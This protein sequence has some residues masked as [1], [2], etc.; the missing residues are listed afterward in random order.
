MKLQNPFSKKIY[1]KILLQN[2]KDYKY[3]KFPLKK[4][5][6]QVKIEDSAY[7]LDEKAIIWLKK[8]PFI[9]FHKGNLIPEYLHDIL[10]LDGGKYEVLT[11][12]RT[13]K[14]VFGGSG[15]DWIAFIVGIAVSS[16]G[17]MVLLFYLQSAGYILI[18]GI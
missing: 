1:I 14:Q 15:F 7:W 5:G 13:L 16:A 4:I 6:E 2:E 3:T 17:I 10:F 12:K 18:R 11:R 8:R 9:V